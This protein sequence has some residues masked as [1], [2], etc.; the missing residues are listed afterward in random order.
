[1]ALSFVEV[2]FLVCTFLPPVVVIAGAILLAMPE[3]RRSERLQAV[4]AH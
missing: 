4:Q 3:R 2:F 1:M